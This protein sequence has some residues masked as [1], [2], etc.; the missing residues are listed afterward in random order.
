MVWKERS[1]VDERVLLVAEYVKGE[2][3]RAELCADKCAPSITIRMNA[4]AGES[5]LPS[6]MAFTWRARL[7]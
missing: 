2:R 7:S 6:P 3:S 4:S 1:R 5:A